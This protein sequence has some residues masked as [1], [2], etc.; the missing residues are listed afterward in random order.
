M[1]QWNAWRGPRSS[2][3]RHHGRTDGSARARFSGSARSRAP[4]CRDH[5]SSA[6]CRAGE[7]TLILALPA[8]DNALASDTHRSSVASPSSRQASER[9]AASGSHLADQEPFRLAPPSLVRARLEAAVPERALGPP[10]GGQYDRSTADSAAKSSVCRPSRLAQDVLPTGITTRG[11]RCD[12]CAC[13]S[14]TIR[15]PADVC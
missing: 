4:L 9:W 3:G 12:Q 5:L 10:I 8:Y 7:V 11:G 2:G 15:C 1:L 6:C 13:S 14:L